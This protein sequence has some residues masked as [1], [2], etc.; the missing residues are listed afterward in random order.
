MIPGSLASL[1]FLP[2]KKRLE[3]L[4]KFDDIRSHY[5]S[6]KLKAMSKLKYDEHLIENDRLD[7]PISS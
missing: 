3:E 5:P 2:T 4:T 7:W 6:W 1:S